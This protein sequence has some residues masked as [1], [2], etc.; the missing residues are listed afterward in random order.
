LG[1][2]GRTEKPLV[3]TENFNPQ[4]GTLD[5]NI[6]GMEGK[7]KS[8]GACR[9]RDRGKSMKRNRRSSWKKGAGPVGKGKGKKSRVERAR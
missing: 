9:A 7:G 4:G 2:K 5:A 3:E 1:E 6:Y 8:G